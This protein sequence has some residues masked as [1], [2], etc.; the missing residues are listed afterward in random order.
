MSR[1]SR[2]GHHKL[3]RAVARGWTTSA[4]LGPAG[5]LEWQRA[6][7]KSRPRGKRRRP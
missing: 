6:E 1:V 4:Q 5:F 3:A 2:S 7:K